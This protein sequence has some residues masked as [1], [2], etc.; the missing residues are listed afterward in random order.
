[1]P[2]HYWVYAR[3][4]VPM[5]S[6]C[7]GAR[8][9]L[10]C[11][12]QSGSFYGAVY[13]SLTIGRYWGQIGYGWVREAMP[14]WMRSMFF[15]GVPI[16]PTESLPFPP[17][18][19][20]DSLHSFSIEKQSNGL[21]S[22]RVDGAAFS[23]YSLDLKDQELIWS[24]SAILSAEAI[25]KVWT[26]KPIL[27]SPAIEYRVGGLWTPADGATAGGDKIK[28]GVE[29]KLQNGSLLPNQLRIGSN[30]GVQSGR[31]F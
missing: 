19:L 6:G 31:L 2:P 24:D 30:I 22:F 23:N 10:Q 8:T 17:A 15:Q 21:W 27:A 26:M 4:S 20:P 3:P 7:T 1:M 11:V 18:P 29:G 25:S 14:F 16:S 5:E 13:V 28:W 12:K 9:T